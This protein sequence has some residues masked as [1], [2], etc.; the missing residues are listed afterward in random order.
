[1]DET[2]TRATR[3]FSQSAGGDL[4]RIAEAA[5]RAGRDPSEAGASAVSK[6][7]DATGQPCLEGGVPGLWRE[8]S[9]RARSQ[10]RALPHTPRW[11]APALTRSATCKPTRCARSWA[12][13]DAH[14]LGVLAPPGRGHLQ[15]WRGPRRDERRFEV[16][17]SGESPS[18]AS[19]PTR[20]AR[21]STTSWRFPPCACRPHD[22]G[23]GAS[24]GRGE[25]DLLRPAR[26]SRR[27][28]QPQRASSCR[29]FPCGMSDDFPIAVEEGPR[30]YD[31]QNSV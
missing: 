29:C 6:T 24:T 18:Q 3:F 25:K 15:A 9:P 14:P 4:Q 22:H 17:V 1:M 13:A 2:E 26:A 11:M 21:R 7:V 23:A 10:A 31:W 20:S 19:R 5:V 16:N 8:P 30:S 12:Y 27:A 28:G